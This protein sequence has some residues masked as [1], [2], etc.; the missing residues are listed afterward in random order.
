M[1]LF[2]KD[3]RLVL[4]DLRPDVSLALTHLRLYLDL[5]YEIK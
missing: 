3:L 4:N 2:F 5:T 1:S